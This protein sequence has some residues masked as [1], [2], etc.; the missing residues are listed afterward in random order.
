MFK[1]DR[2]GHVHS[3]GV[4]NNKQVPTYDFDHDLIDLNLGW[5]EQHEDMISIGDASA[6]LSIVVGWICQSRRE[7]PADIMAVAAKAEAILW[8]LNPEQ[9][10]YE[11]LT[12]IATACGYTKAA[13]SKYLLDF[14]DQCGFLAS[15]GKLNSSRE[16]FRQT[17]LN[18]VKE[19]RHAS[20][21]TRK[22]KTEEPSLD[23]VGD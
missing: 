6:L 1:E 17:Q 2:S 12:A 22:R 16:T 19:G 8:M 9:S 13:V 10:K 21:K 23:A 11:S 5:T 4:E 14:R 15:G 3:T 20:V 18:L 7:T